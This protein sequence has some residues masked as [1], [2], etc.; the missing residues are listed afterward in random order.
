[1]PVGCLPPTQPPSRSPTHPHP[2][3]HRPPWVHIPCGLLSAR[4]PPQTL[5]ATDRQFQAQL[6][7]IPSPISTRASGKPGTHHLPDPITKPGVAAAPP[8]PPVLSGIFKY[9]SQ[10]R[11]IHNFPS[12]QWSV[13]LLP[14]PTPLCHPRI[15]QLKTAQKMMMG[16]GGLR[17]FTGQGRNLS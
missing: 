4:V 8:A 1:M 3:P 11:H 12:A 14:F 5:F 2:H 17:G 15:N 6:C 9:L 7:I 10:E 16:S 13:F